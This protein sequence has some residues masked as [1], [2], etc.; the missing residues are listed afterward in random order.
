MS[1]PFLFSK[2]WEPDPKMVIFRS[3]KLHAK[4]SFTLGEKI[5]EKARNCPRPGENAAAGPRKRAIIRLHCT[6]ARKIIKRLL[7]LLL[8]LSRN[9]HHYPAAAA[10]LLTLSPNFFCEEQRERENTNDKTNL[11]LSD[12][13]AI[14]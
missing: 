3:Y 6:A 13:T 1:R 4:T 8:L 2:L 9:C 7:L 10:T 11:P 14:P 5:R 12:S